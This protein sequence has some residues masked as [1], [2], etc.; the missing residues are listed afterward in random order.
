[1]TKNNPYFQSVHFAVQNMRCKLTDGRACA[2]C[3]LGA[4]NEV[5]CWHGVENNHSAPTG[6]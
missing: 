2:W 6:R 4:E 3:A 1:M 5:W